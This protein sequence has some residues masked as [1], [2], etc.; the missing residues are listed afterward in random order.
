MKK[1]LLVLASVALLVFAFAAVAGAKYAGYA[2]DGSL[3]SSTAT[4]SASPGYLSWGGAQHLMTQNGA[5]ANLTGTAHGGYVTTTTKCAVCHSVHRA[6]GIGV[7]TGTAPANNSTASGVVNQFLTAGGA[8]CVQCH[9]TW[10]ATPVSQLVEWAGPST[11]QGGPH[12]SSA[13]S[14]CHQGGIHGS[15]NSMY[16]GMNAYML[17]NTNDAQITAELPLQQVYSSSSLT[18]FISGTTYANT[19]GGVPVGTTVANFVAGKT[20]LTGYTCSRP[21]CHVNSV[22]VNQAWGQTFSRTDAQTGT[23]GIQMT[24]HATNFGGTSHNA[25]EGCGPCH[26]GNA[27]GGYR[28]ASATT[29]PNLTDVASARA[30]GCDQCHDA[31]GQATN[32]TAFPHG[33]RNIAIYEWT[34]PAATGV[35]ASPEPNTSITADAGNIWMY[36][37]SMAQTGTTAA[38]TA[39]AGVIDPTFTL[40]QGAVGPDPTGN[41]GNIN[42][43]TC[44]KCHVP[45]DDASAT[46]MGLASGTYPR[47]TQHAR[48]TTV[49]D[50]TSL[51]FRSYQFMYMWF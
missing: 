18:W 40:I 13:C 29:T 21:G 3:A 45:Y 1:Y 23:T 32:S 38:G 10:G 34:T 51:A 41:V 39:G 6:V 37:S 46:A 5:P 47:A 8:S 35:A 27:A 49:P 15:G 20:M 9:C 30:Y 26:T 22:F 25:Q 4:S 28:Y 7:I 24:G 2:K 43:A 17:G 48:P 14:T 44:L 31:V 42:D 19:T 50:I 12:S 16:H 33:N 36:A 11:P